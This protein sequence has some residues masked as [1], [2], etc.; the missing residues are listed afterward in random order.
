MLTKYFTATGENTRFVPPFPG[1]QLVI[2]EVTM[3]GISPVLTTFKEPDL[4]DTGKIIMQTLSTGLVHWFHY[5]K[6]PVY[7]TVDRYYWTVT[8]DTNVTIVYEWKKPGT[9]LEIIQN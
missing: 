2:Y 5:T 7:V 8:S 9:L 6:T 4:S 3:I 1:A